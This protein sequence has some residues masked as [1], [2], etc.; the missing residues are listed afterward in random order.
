[1]TK[2]EL[3]KLAIKHLNSKKVQSIKKQI[4]D[5][6]TD[7]KQKHD[8]MTA[9]DKNFIKSFISAREKQM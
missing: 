2:T 7:K 1:M 9:F 4:C 3:R 8:C 5:R 6:F